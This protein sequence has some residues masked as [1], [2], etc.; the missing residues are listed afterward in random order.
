MQA[1]RYARYRSISRP[2]IQAFA[3]SLLGE[4]S[5]LGVFITT[6]SFTK[7]A[8][9]YAQSLSNQSVVLV[10]GVGLAGHMI[11]HGVG[12]QQ[13]ESYRLHRIDMDYFEAD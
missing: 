5:N 10:D 4:G 6:S 1:K 8:Q 3:G 12:V 2:D 9:A 7:G 13:V 11:D